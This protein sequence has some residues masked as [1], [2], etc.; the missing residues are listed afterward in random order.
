M[1]KNKKIIA[2]SLSAMVALMS[3]GTSV[4]YASEVTGTISSSAPSGSQVQ[5]TVGGS[6][7]N[8]GG[9]IS[10]TV[11]S[12]SNGGG[13][14]GGG[15]GSTQQNIPTGNVLGASTVA[16]ADPNAPGLPNSGF[17]SNQIN[18]L[19]VLLMGAMVGAL[20]PLAIIFRRKKL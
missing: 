15:G 1:K 18:P 16:L 10:G 20:T 11:T 3:L 19:W 8:S 6:T 13:G 14:G 9:N 7:T 12:P 5:G 17:H 4:A 2:M